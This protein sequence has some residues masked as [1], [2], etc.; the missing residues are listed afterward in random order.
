MPEKNKIATISKAIALDG[1]IF[2]PTALVFK[3]V[4][5][6]TLARAGHYLQT[7]EGCRAWWWGDF[8]NCYCTWKLSQQRGKVDGEQ[9][10]RQF[11]HYTAEFAALSGLE[12]CTLKQWRGVSVFYK[13]FSRLNGLSWSHHQEAWVGAGGNLDVALAWLKRSLQE[14]WSKT[15]LRAAI[16][17]EA[18]HDIDDEPPAPSRYAEVL[19]FKVWV[20]RASKRIGSLDD[21]EAMTLRQDLQPAVDLAQALD[22]RLSEANGRPKNYRGSSRE[23]PAKV[24]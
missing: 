7:V 12:E 18:Q 11:I 19:A 15:E 2:T 13:P 24:T 23:L 20:T 9:K 10:E 8:I 16:R 5:K 6:A 17:K 14:D 22:S 3:Q 4:D 21:L 1:C